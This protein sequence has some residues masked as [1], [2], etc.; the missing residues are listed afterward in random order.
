VN[1]GVRILL[2]DVVVETVKAIL[3]AQGSANR[4]LPLLLF[5]PQHPPQHHL[6]F[7]A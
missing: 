1:K 6:K 2:E 7:L 4:Y 3:S 5:V